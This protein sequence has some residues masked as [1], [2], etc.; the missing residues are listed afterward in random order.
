LDDV[1]CAAIFAWFSS[2]RSSGGRIFMIGCN[3]FI[4]S[5]TKEIAD[6]LFYKSEQTC[7]PDEILAFKQLSV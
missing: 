1:T 7:W 5:L 2:A 6:C 4:D 3:T